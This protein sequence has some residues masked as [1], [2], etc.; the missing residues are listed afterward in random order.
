[1]MNQPF[2]G[3]RD[4]RTGLPVFLSV[5][6]CCSIGGADTEN[7]DDGGVDSDSETVT[8]TNTASDSDSDGDSD[9]DIDLDV[10]NAIDAGPRL[11]GGPIQTRCDCRAIGTSGRA[12]LL[13][14]F[15]VS[16]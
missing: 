13:E 16:L 8:S 3:Q 10:D 6:L 14:L 12:S 9:T 5:V 4:L 1:M 11:V 7:N 2:R 15:S